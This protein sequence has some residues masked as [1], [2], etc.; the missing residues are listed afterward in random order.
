MGRRRVICVLSPPPREGS[1]ERLRYSTLQIYTAPSPL[2]GGP[3]NWI[4]GFLVDT[5][6]SVTYMPS[7]TRTCRF[8]RYSTA[9][10]WY[11]TLCWSR[12]VRICSLTQIASSRS[13]LV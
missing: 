6:E 10:S 9:M 11:F 1:L 13:W 8:V 7:S 2:Y 3:P 5:A 12:S 4:P